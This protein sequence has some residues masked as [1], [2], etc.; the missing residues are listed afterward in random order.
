M[1]LA[2]FDLF[3][4]FRWGLAV[5]C[6]I[7]A[8]VVTWQSAV[9]WLEWFQSSPETARLGRYTAALLVRIRLRRFTWELLQIAALGAAFFYIVYLHRVLAQRFAD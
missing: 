2:E 6:T 7:Y 3:E 5:V 8:A 9:G 4:T 1:L